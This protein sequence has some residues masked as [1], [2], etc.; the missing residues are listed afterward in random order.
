MN[1]KELLH[2]GKAMLLAV[3]PYRRA[4]FLRPSRVSVSRKVAKRAAKILIGDPILGTIG[5]ILG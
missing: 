1:W 3:S 2:F 5:Y 4:L